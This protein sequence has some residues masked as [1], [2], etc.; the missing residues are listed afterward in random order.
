MKK[1]GKKVLLT[2][3][4]AVCLTGYP[5]DAAAQPNDGQA[6]SNAAGNNGKQVTSRTM[7]E[8]RYIGSETLPN[9]LS[10]KGTLA[11]GLSGIS[12][13]PKNNKWV[14]LSDDRSDINPARFYTAKL[15][16]NS[17]DFQNVQLIDVTYFKQPDGTFYPD[18]GQYLSEMTG[19]V[20]DP[21]SI[22]INPENGHIWYTSEGDRSLGLNPYIHQVAW[23]GSYLSEIPVTDTIKMDGQSEKGFRNN[24]ALEGA[25]FSADG[26]TFWTAMEGPL[27]QDD[28]LPTPD[29]GALSRITQYDSNGNVLAEYAYPIDAIPEEPGEGKHAD[30]G[31]TEILSINEHELL[32]LERASVQSDDGDYSNYVRMYKI[33]I[34]GATDIQE[35][36][37]IKGKNINPVKKELISDVNTLGLDKVDNIEGMSWGKRLPNGNDSLVLVSDNNFNDS[38]ITQFIA[39]E[40]IP[41]NE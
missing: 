8:V 1:T 41:E 23:D 6:N 25:S 15:H 37:S 22:R 5:L 18:R 10:Y 3:M 9:D 13:H 35:L 34:N 4:A 31:V 32:V 20:P 24:L 40:V 11:G 17:K 26:Q 2:S 14:V 19:V 36:E 39:L 30:N 38:Q 21:E 12:Y 33:D 29:S 27:L 7:E 16:Y 28:K